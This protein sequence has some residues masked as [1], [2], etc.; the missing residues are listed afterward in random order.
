MLFWGKS[1]SESRMIRR[2]GLFSVVGYVGCAGLSLLT[3][4]G[5]AFLIGVAFMMRYLLIMFAWEYLTRKCFS[6]N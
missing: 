1:V 4:D 6:M 5:I 2:E 3:Q